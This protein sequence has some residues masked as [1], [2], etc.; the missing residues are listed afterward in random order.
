[1]AAIQRAVKELI[2]DTNS[3]PIKIN[4]KIGKEMVGMQVWEQF[5]KFSVG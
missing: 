2:I 5:H 3:L 1:M 4:I